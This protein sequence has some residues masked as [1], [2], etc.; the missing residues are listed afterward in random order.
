MCSSVPG[1]GGLE[2]GLRP[3]STDGSVAVV[4]STPARRWRS[5]LLDHPD[6]VSAA[7]RSSHIWR[8]GAWLGALGALGG[9][10]DHHLAVAADEVRLDALGLGQDLDVVEAGEQLLPEDPQ[11]ELGEPAAHAA[12]GA[13]AE[14]EVVAGVAPVDDEAVGLL[15]AALVAVGGG[16]PHHDLVALAD[17]L[18]VQDGVLRSDAAHVGQRGLPAQ[19]LV[20]HLRHQR[21]L[22]AQPVELVGELVQRQHAAG[23]GVAGGVVAADDQEGQVAEELHRP[24]DD[25]LGVLRHLHERDE[26]VAGLLAGREP[27]GLVVPELAEGAGRLGGRGVDLVGVGGAAGGAGAAGHE[28][29]PL[30]ELAAL[31]VGEV[32]Q[33]REHPR[34]QLDADVADPVEGL[35]DGQGVQDLRDAFADEG[36]HLLEVLGRHHVLDRRATLVVAGRVEGDEHLDVQALGRGAED[37]LRLG[38]EGLEVLVDGDDVVVP[39]DRPERAEGA[40]GAE[41]HRRLVA[42]AA[43]VGLPLAL[44]PQERVAGVDLGEV[45]VLDVGQRGLGEARLVVAHDQALAALVEVQRL[46]LALHRDRPLGLLDGLLEARLHDGVDHGVEDAHD[47]HL[48]GLRERVRR[49]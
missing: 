33:G 16:V 35:P 7:R 41:V 45:E 49:K 9:Q 11:L 32:Q 3:S 36:L 44:P 5:S 24:V 4:V 25:V 1:R 14:G 34:G 20:D 46:D 26:V 47:D 39:R 21:G 23:H 18:A 29:G 12:V 31:V 48:H 19:D 28:V 13:D 27:G 8:V 6:V 40:V 2:T 42:Q 38:G 10:A 37:D 22:G 43:E 17:E 15:E 30:G